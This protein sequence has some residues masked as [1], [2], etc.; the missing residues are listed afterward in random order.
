MTAG[1]S[2]QRAAEP[3]RRAADIAYDRIETLVS[4]LV[5]APGN[6]VVEAELI[7]MI[8]LGRTPVREALMRMVSIGLVV[9][10]PRRGLMVSTIDVMAYLDLLQTRRVLEQLIAANAAR[11]ASGT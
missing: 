2:R 4:K 10:Q 11:R 8:G 9:Q 5:I 3:R 6:P 7:E 1:S